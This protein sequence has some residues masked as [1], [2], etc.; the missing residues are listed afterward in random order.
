MILFWG[1]IPDLQVSSVCSRLLEGFLEEV[2]GA[3]E[4]GPS[5]PAASVQVSKLPAHRSGRSW[6]EN[7]PWCRARG[8]GVALGDLK[9]YMLP[10][11]QGRVGGL[12]SAG[13]L[14][15]ICLQRVS[16]KQ[17]HRHLLPSA[18][19]TCLPGAEVGRISSPDFQGAPAVH[20]PQGGG[21]AHVEDPL[22]PQPEGSHH[23]PEWPGSPDR[24]PRPTG[25]VH[26]RT[27]LFFDPGAE[28][29]VED[30]TTREAPGWQG[31]WT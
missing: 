29:G 18:P 19:H 25:Y 30:R 13:N 20:G 21:R 26:L 9:A 6:C 12:D 24:S 15:R 3:I 4:I 22:G 27:G 14:L 10:K 17:D 8:S 16:Y 7:W 11:T 31:V 1:D 23:L 2:T 28:L 5:L